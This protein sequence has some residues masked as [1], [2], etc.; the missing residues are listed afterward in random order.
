VLAADPAVT[1]VFAAN[2]QM[3]LGLLRA[4]ADAGRGVPD[5]VA[6]LGFDDIADAAEFRPPLS[7]IRQDF[8]ALGELAVRLVVDRVEGRDVQDP[9]LLTPA[10]IPRASA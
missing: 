8:A 2:D 1:A 4:L 6:V 7:T 9:A 3:A 10:L 5:D